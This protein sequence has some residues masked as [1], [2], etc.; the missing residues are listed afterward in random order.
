MTKA[1]CLV[2]LALSFA[3]FAAANACD[4]AVVVP[5]VDGGADAPVTV[6]GGDAG[7]DADP[8]PVP[9]GKR[10]LGIGTDVTDP[11]FP[12]DVG[13]VLDAGAKA[14]SLALAWDEIERPYDGGV[15]GGDDGGD[16]GPATVIFQP[17]L[18]VAN[19]VY[20]GLGCQAV[21]EIDALDGSGLR[22]PADL[23]GRAI[24]DTELGARFDRITDYV[25]DQTRDTKAVALVVASAVDVTLADDATKY[26]AFGTFF[27]RA[28][29]HAHAVRPGVTVAFSVTGPGLVLRKDRLATALAA[30]DA[31]AVIVHPVLEGS[32]VARPPSVIGADLDAIVAAAPAGKPVLITSAS[33]PS[34]SASGSDEAAQAA[35]VTALFRAWDRHADRVPVLV[36]GALDDDPGSGAVTRARREGRADPAFVTFVASTGLRDAAKRPKRAFGGMLGEARARGF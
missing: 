24:D 2:A 21:F 12:S 6:D 8:A 3:A 35:F 17:A 14:T 26:A 33:Y 25:L 10:V 30:S 31:V 13:A 5:I 16:A 27:A 34:A 7:V 29:A 36:L 9:K 23:A 20:E 22:A 19:L 11:A 32:A 1:R 15:D 4:D 18:H 28:A